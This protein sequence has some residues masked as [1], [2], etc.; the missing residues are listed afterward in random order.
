MYSYTVSK[1]ADSLEFNNVCKK[2]E[3]D[4]NIIKKDKLLVDVD[5]SEIQKYTT[6]DGEIKVCND[7]EIDAVYIDSDIIIEDILG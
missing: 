5:G 7:Y 4:L 2:I 1:T 6:Q 3:S